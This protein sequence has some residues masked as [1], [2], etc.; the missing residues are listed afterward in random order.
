MED[1]AT[2]LHTTARFGVVDGL[3]VGYVEKKP[4]P[5]PGTLFPNAARLPLHE[6]GLRL[7]AG[8]LAGTLAYGLVVLPGTPAV[9]QLRQLAARRGAAVPG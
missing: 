6:S 8:G 4:Q 7:A 2:S 9:G 5:E 1:L 3:E